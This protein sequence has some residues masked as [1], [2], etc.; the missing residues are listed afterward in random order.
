MLALLL[1]VALWVAGSALAVVGVRLA[2]ERRRP[3]ALGGALLAP[4]GLLLV[5]LA[6]ARVCAAGWLRG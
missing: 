1:A 3:A 5:Y 4:A 6:L 2:A